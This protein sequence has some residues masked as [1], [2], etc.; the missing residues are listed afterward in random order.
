LVYEDQSLTYAQ[1]NTQA[2]R[3]AHH[4]IDQGVRP[5]DNVVTLLERSPVLVI[6][7]LAILKAGATYVPLDPQSL[8]TRQY[9]TITDCAARLVLADTAPDPDLE[10]P[11]P[12]LVLNDETIE[13]LP[14]AEP[15]SCHRNSD[16]LAYVMYTS[17]STG[18]PKGVL[19]PH[20]AISRLVVNSGFAALDADD[21]VAFAANPAF[22]A[23]T[24]EVWAPLLN[25]GTL[26]V[27]DRDT[28]RSP[29]TFVDTLQLAQIDVMWLTVGLFNEFAD[30]LAPMLHQ[31]KTLI[32]GGDVLDPIFIDRILNDH[33][34]QRLLNG[35]GPT[36][37]T[38]FATTFVVHTLTEGTTR[39]PI[40]RPIANT[41]IYLLDAY[42]QPVPL[43]AV[44]EIYIGGA[45]VA[46]G[47]LNRPDLTAE[48]FLAD[49]FVDKPDAKM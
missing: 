13:T 32:I 21:R 27:I 26:V 43:G 7:E 42:G 19:V 18:T 44:G 41:R 37:T 22:D 30:A 34:P 4:L 45:G 9:W 36:E 35:Y 29:S 11:V 17:G 39:I 1:L 24:F 14:S 31:L 33:P 23:S 8:S 48:R 5:D 20:R 6:A 28:V 10:F 46:R 2:N 47:Y 15:T 49:P 12:V 40:G 38:T 25:G 16:D 3:L